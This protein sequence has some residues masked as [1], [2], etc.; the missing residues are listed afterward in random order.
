MRTFS[1][2]IFGLIEMVNKKYTMSWNLHSLIFA[3]TNILNSQLSNLTRISRVFPAN[4]EPCAMFWQKSHRLEWYLI[5]WHYLN[6]YCKRGY[7]RW[8]KISRKRW[9]DMSRGG[10]FHDITHISF[11]QAYGFYFRMG[12]I[13]AK[14]TKARKTWNYPHTKISTFTVCVV[15]WFIVMILT[16]D[17]RILFSS[18]HR[19]SHETDMCTGLTT[20]AWST[21][22]PPTKTRTSSAAR[23]CSKAVKSYKQYII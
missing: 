22:S 12:V 14:K 4:F 11:T 16:L 23:S 13:F 21:L 6:L 3:C 9:Q 20:P 8:G 7:F 2:L 19:A 5:I 18:T 10:N 17:R 1:L 15:F